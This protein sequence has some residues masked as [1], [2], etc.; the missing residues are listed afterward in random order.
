MLAFP[1]TRDSV[2][3]LPSGLRAHR[4]APS[5]RCIPTTASIA[6]HTVGHIRARKALSPVTC[7]WCRTPVATYAQ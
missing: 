5:S 2:A 4:T 7:Q 3:S 1:V 6:S